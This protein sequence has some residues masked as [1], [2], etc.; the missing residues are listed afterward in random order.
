MRFDWQGKSTDEMERHF[1]PR[2]TVGSDA[3][4]ALLADYTRMSQEVRQ[5]IGGNLNIRYGEN[6]KET[7]DV[8]PARNN[9][10]GDPAPA[11]VFIHGGFWRAL[12][13]DDHSFIAEHFVEAGVTV[14][15]VN[16]D[17][18]PSVTL[19]ELVEEARRAFAFIY[20]HAAEWNIDPKR[21]FV[22]GHSAG[23]HLTA[24]LFSDDFGAR[25]LPENAMRGAILI[26]GIYEPQVVLHITVNDEAKISA[27]AAAR[28]DCFAQ[29]PRRKVQSL[30]SVGGNESQGWRAQ[31]FGYAEKLEDAGMNI[32][33]LDV[34]AT[35]HFTILMDAVRP[36]GMGFKAIMAEIRAASE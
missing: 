11:F 17:L 34:P 22:G 12:D 33:V 36:D 25:G 29:T 27:D 24:M 35:N 28:N 14:V 5:K 19:D 16:Y 7:L 21:I 31:T 20:H 18:C 1:N 26:S 3:V 6:E 10:L 23:A 30:V 4:T 9:A 8:H 32:A 2:A 15:N 13:K